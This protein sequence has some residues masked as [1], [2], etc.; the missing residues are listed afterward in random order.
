MNCITYESFFLADEFVHY[1]VSGAT[2]QRQY[3]CMLIV[4]GSSALP[5]EQTP[6]P[7]R[8][9]SI[10]I[11]ELLHSSYKDDKNIFPLFPFR[12]CKFFPLLENTNFIQLISTRKSLLDV[13]E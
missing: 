9:N 1:Q 5:L 8:Q 11:Q 4:I 3:G 2:E 7:S 13:C 12:R 6:R 10:S